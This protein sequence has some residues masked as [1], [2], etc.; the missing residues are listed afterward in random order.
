MKRAFFIK[1]FDEDKLKITK[2]Q[3]EVESIISQEKYIEKGLC[4]MKEVLNETQF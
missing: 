3:L 2:A 4:T 1:D